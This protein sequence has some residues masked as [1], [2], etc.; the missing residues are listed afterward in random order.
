MQHRSQPPSLTQASSNSS[1]TIFITGG[2]SPFLLTITE[3][4]SSSLL[5]PAT[6][7]STPKTILECLQALTPSKACYRS[8]KNP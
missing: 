8:F 3:P 7:E 4:P 6:T 2:P 5:H 1:F